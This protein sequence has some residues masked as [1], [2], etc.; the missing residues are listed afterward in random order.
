M[1]DPEAIYREDNNLF[2]RIIQIILIIVNI[3]HNFRTLQLP[4]FSKSLDCLDERITIYL[5]T[6]IFNNILL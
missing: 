2:I 3:S 6:Y 1:P 5:I 4:I